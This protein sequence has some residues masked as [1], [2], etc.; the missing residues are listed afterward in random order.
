MRVTKL[1]RI[2]IGISSL[3]VTGVYLEE[4]CV[5]LPVK[6]SWRL[7][8]CSEC[9]RI[10]PGYDHAH[11]PV[12]WVHLGIGGLRLILEYAPRRVEC[13]DCGVRVEMV[14]W[15]RPGSRFT[16]PFE[17]MT[18]YLA[19]I[20]NKTEVARIMGISWR[21]VGNIVE[22]VVAEKLD[23]NRLNGL[24][25][26]GVDEFS[27]RK[28]HRYITTVVDHET[29]RI[30]W[31]K[32]GKSSETLD[33][34]F[35]QL[36]DE[37]AKQ[38]EIVTIDMSAAFIKSIQAKA[39]GA[40]IVYDLFHVLKLASEAVDEVRREKVRKL[41]D[42]D[43]TEKAAAVK[44]SRYALL[45]NPWDLSAKEWDKL[46][47]IQKHNAP[48]YRAYLLKESLAAV[49]QET[50]FDDA[51]H[52]LERWLSWASRSKLKQFVKVAR[53]IREHKDGVLA[54]VTTK[55]TNGLVEGFNNKL[56][57]IARR[58]FGFHSSAALIGMLFL[59]CGGVALNPPLPASW[60]T[61]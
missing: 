21:T 43:D 31:A 1:A 16:K 60:C 51:K 32:E 8:R 12:R 49:F 41:R 55:L 40:T 28:R 52:E 59:C 27:Y 36:G 2:L 19:Q 29:C 54:Y 56:R 38:I 25:R 39:A 30:V 18:A 26:I 47:A 14:P 23:P 45:K 6:P 46:A 11:K 35:D 15:A 17:E 34:F 22:R 58:A 20:T 37:R 13:P 5:V 48:L 7:P 24:R 57:M 50:S 42:L 33:A 3:F 4:V 44:K 9:T 61:W 53:T 10:C